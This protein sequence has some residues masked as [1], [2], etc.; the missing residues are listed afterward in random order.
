[1]LAQV[2]ARSLEAQG[3]QATVIPAHSVDQMV[4]DILGA[5][6][7]VLIIDLDLGPAGTGSDVLSRLSSERAEVRSVVLTGSASELEHARAIVA[8]AAAVML[9]TADLESL[10]DAV[11]QVAAGGTRID[12]DRYAAART[13]LEE[14]ASKH[15][16]SLRR[17][18]MLTTRERAV[19]EYLR[20][21]VRAASIADMESLS[22]STVRTHIRSILLK[23]GVNSQLEAVA[24][25][26]S[27]EQN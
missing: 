19:L 26:K 3:A 27:I 1:M 4:E 13:L 10:V 20:T 25:L 21:G 11:S 12:A 14:W 23:L 8:G 18:A 22:V 9:K 15:S 7:A 5:A 16:D 24:L 17:L 6:P 2:L